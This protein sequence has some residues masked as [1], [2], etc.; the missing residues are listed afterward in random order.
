MTFIV[1][2]KKYS[3]KL[4]TEE[5]FLPIRNYNIFAKYNRVK[6]SDERVA[7]IFLHEGLGSVESWGN[8]PDLLAARTGIS[9]ICYDRRGYGRSS[10]YSFMSNPNYMKLEASQF[11]PEILSNFNVK[12]PIFIGHSDG[13]T[14][15]LIFA[16]IY[17]D[18]KMSVVSIAAHSFVEKMTI[19][20]IKKA[21]VNYNSGK[22]KANLEKIHFNK[23]DQLFSSWSSTWLTNEFIKYNIFEYL[24][25]IKCPLLLIQGDADEYGTIAQIHTIKSIVPSHVESR[26]IENCGHFPINTNKLEILEICNNFAINNNPIDSNNNHNKLKL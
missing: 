6:Y 4:E 16:G 1:E 3:Y 18:I 17:T 5:Y 25:K 15:A 8:F 12:Y 10:S 26:I 7:L 14:I 13:A 20:G 9:S 2:N 21:I 22:L 24:K 11:L 19:Q 23:T